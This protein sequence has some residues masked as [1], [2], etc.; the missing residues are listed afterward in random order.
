M[1]NKIKVSIEFSLLIFVLA[2]LIA[3]ITAITVYDTSKQNILFL[4]ITIFVFSA[5]LF[6]FLI[7]KKLWI[8]RLSYKDEK[9]ETAEQYYHDFIA[10]AGDA[11][12]IL[13]NKNKIVDLNDCA[14]NL[15]GYS[16]EELLQKEFI[17]LIFQGE[18]DALESAEFCDQTK[19]RLIYRKVKRKDGALI[20]AE[21]TNWLIKDNG[22][23]AIIR[24]VTEKKSAEAII[25]ESE[26]KYR[27]LFDNNPAHII[28]WD[29]E[30]LKVLEV[31]NTILKSH[32]YSESEWE[33]MSILDN[34]YEENYQKSKDLAILLLNSDEAVFE[35]RAKYLKKN[36]EVMFLEVTSYKIDYNNKK[37]V[38]SI[39]RDVSEQIKAEDKLRQSEEKYHSLVEHAGDAIF[40]IAQNK[41]II[42]VNSATC[43]LLGYSR[44][45]LLNI[46]FLD[47]YPRDSSDY[48][49][50]RWDLIKDGKNYLTET[51]LQRKD[52]SFVEVEINRKQ[53]DDVSY[54]SIVRDVSE[55]KKIENELV[56][57]KEKLRLFIENSPASLAMFDNDMRYISRSRSWMVD[58]N[59][60]GQD[61]I[62]K[63]H[64]DIFPGLSQEWKDIHQS[65]LKGNI[66][67]REE[68]FFIRPD[69]NVEWIRWEIHPWK[70][71]SEEIGGIIM[72]VDIIT[73]RKHAVE[74]F[75]QQFENSPDTIIYV[76]KQLKIESINR[77][78]FL[79][80]A[81]DELIGRDCVSILPESSQSFVREKLEKSFETGKE[82]EFEYEISKGYW[83][84]TRLVPIVFNDVVTHV[85]VFSTDISTRKE[86]EQKLLQSEEKYRVVTENISD[87]ILLVNK[88]FKIEYLSPSAERISG[89]SSEEVNSKLIFDFIHPEDLEK[90]RNFFENSFSSPGVSMQKQLRTINKKGKAIWIE[91]TI[92]NLLGKN[93]EGS[94]VINY[95]DITNR[96]KLEEQQALMA[97]IVNSSDDA[98][99]SKNIN[100]IVTS[101]NVGAERILGYT[102]DEMIGKNIG[103]LVPLG[104]RDE[105]V[106]I[107]NTIK[108]GHSVEH[109]ET[110]RVKKNGDLIDVSL[111]ISPVRD[112]LGN[113]VG[114]SKIMR[115][116]TDRK[117][118]EQ[119]LIQ[120]NAELKKANS[121]L[122]R[123]VYSASHDLRA[124][125]KSILGL[126]SITKDYV[127]ANNTELLEC[128]SML[129]SSVFKLD[130]FIE[131]ILSYSRN[132]RMELD[133]D[134]I[135]FQELLDKIKEKY[136]FIN[137]VEK[138]KVQIEINS[139]SV[140][141]SDFKRLSIILN[142]LLSNAFKYRDETKEESHVKIIFTNNSERAIIRLEDNG[143]GIAEKDIEKVF[144]MFYRATMLSTGSGLGLYI[145]KETLDKLEGNISVE[146][147][148]GKGTSF[149][150]EIPNQIN[151]YKMVPPSS[152]EIN[153]NN[154]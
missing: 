96:K 46:N 100:G 120:N 57:N 140:F 59:L 121:E 33:N 149:T 70:L 150:I 73:E 15:F 81:V 154:K 94:Y 66:E 141:V 71:A 50:A 44:E 23:F 91:G 63:K 107:L 90:D 135:D 65:C 55:R 13:N 31:N 24:D 93:N 61:I 58:Y 99:I 42:E 30:T 113:V 136:K 43:Q 37:A 151:N 119:E 77:D 19:S 86:A 40:V 25:K 35:T 105:E 17:E 138:L 85:L 18:A 22:S 106:K 87:A 32:G 78:T 123:F 9:L 7:K 12:L 111:T 69:G 95:R 118:I 108:S 126:L 53:L 131:D 144:S 38:L 1:I 134:E 146:S 11:I 142:N 49:S 132:S 82:Q 89:Y 125:L 6:Y 56:E 34:R 62:G 80:F 41:N 104:C 101:W 114:A 83:S 92:V 20:D 129:N 98:I 28:I 16:R 130:S 52:G 8:Q 79:N 47:M 68:D 133:K 3:G 122:D 74:M 139:E 60:L 64:Y 115:N 48:F 148:L 72:F 2:V 21:I 5:L 39:A 10:Y 128:L 36:R 84:C 116:I 145:V 117:E 137:G 45:E 147:K 88:N 112:V 27:Y 26:E 14:C 51:R 4:M 75:K 152:A 67:Q 29:F 76:N 103:I 110:R 127:D 124:P 54:L 153:E 143:I 97:S 109:F 102:A